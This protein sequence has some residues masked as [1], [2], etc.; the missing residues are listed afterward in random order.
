MVL[1]PTRDERVAPSRRHDLGAAPAVSLDST[2]VPALA[3]QR[4]VLLVYLQ[5]QGVRGERRLV[6]EDRG[7]GV[8]ELGGHPST[9]DVTLRVLHVPRALGQK[10]LAARLDHGPP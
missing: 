2:A 3:L 4:P 8:A 1:G 6:F 7:A 10:R 5:I 9:G